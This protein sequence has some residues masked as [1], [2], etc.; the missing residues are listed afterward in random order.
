ME[1]KTP[2]S[3]EV[4]CFQFNSKSDVSKSNSNILG[5]NNFFLENH[6]TSEGAISHNV[7]YHQH[8]SID[9]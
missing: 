9:R 7:L 1:E 4:V 3:H 2:L 5:E 8:L 6:V